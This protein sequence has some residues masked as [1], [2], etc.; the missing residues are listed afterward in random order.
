MKK[1]IQNLPAN[2]I[3]YV[4]NIIK[5]KRKGKYASVDAELTL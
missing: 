3:S 1:N 5:I 2:V 4:I